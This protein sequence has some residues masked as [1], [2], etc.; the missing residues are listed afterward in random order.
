M[1]YLLRNPF[2]VKLIGSLCSPVSSLFLAYYICSLKCS[3]CF[4]SECRERERLVST[5]VRR[6]KREGTILRSRMAWWQRV[7]WP[8]SFHRG[9]AGGTWTNR[10]WGQLSWVIP[11]YRESSPGGCVIL[12]GLFG[13]CFLCGFMWLSTSWAGKALGCGFALQLHSLFL[14]LFVPGLRCRRCAVS[15]CSEPWATDDCGAGASHC[16]GFSCST[17]AREHRLTSCGACTSLL[18]TAHGIFPDQGLNPCPLCRQ[19]DS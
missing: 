11:S 17:W 14:V 16:R 1:W 9:T 6:A 18:S 10:R 8:R 15:G 12:C 7:L 4:L 19:A 13:V 5:W 3:D 2:S